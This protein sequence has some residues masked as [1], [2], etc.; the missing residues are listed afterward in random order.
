MS[1]SRLI[2][3]KAPR[4]GLRHRTGQ[5]FVVP[6]VVPIVVAAVTAACIYGWPTHEKGT[7]LA[8]MSSRASLSSGEQSMSGSPL[9]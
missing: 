1:R 4:L 3:R 5:P 2:G 8:A 9:F 7:S 6:I